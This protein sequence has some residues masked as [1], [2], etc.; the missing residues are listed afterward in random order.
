MSDQADDYK[1]R[2]AAHAVQFVQSGM[3]VGLG[4][5]STAIHATRGIAALLRQGALRDV[6]GFATS[7]AVWQEAV[8][9]GIPMLTEDMPRAIDL[10]IDGADEID[11]A[12][13]LIK[14]GGGALLREKIVAQA[15]L[16]VIIIADDSKLSDRLGLRQA[17]PVEVLPFGWRSQA[18]FLE[19]LGARVNVRHT[20]D[21]QDA[22]TDQ[23][24]L[25]LDCSFGGIADA[26]GLAGLL[27]ARAGVVGHGLFL[28]LAHDVIVAGPGGIKHMQ[29][30][31][32]SG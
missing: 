15:S 24:N 14:G 20:P 30:A 21:G 28:G 7:R 31:G 26:A 2:A 16:R 9:L 25:I 13:N 12:L 10:T 19:S 1:Q 8:R 3:L 32:A 17:L 23:D 29:R 27:S 6:V 22:R 18:R 5:G 4:T 11:P